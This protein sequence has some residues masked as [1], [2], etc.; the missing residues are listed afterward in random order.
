MLVLKEST[1]E[2]QLKKHGF[3]R[4][5]KPYPGFYLCLSRDSK[6]IF[7]G[8]G[9]YIF[10]WV[11]DDPRIHARANCQYKCRKT[12]LDVIY[13]MIMDGIVEERII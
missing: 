10:D 2:E 11:D 7:I 4:C 5:K 8:D 9:I 12:I 13:E 1:T 3:V 6:M